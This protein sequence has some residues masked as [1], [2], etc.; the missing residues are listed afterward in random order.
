MVVSG[1]AAYTFLYYSLK[2]PLNLPPWKDPETL[3]LGLLFLLGPIGIILT[4]IAAARGASKSVVV[5]LIVASAILFL[6]GLLE[7]M[8]V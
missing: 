2:P 4:V 6:V 3:D 1:Y 7:G 8:S 5:P